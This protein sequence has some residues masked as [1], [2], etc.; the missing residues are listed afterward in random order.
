MTTMVFSRQS[1]LPAEV[2][3]FV[4]RREELSRLRAALGTHRLVTLVGPGGVGKTRLA[5]RAARDLAD[6]TPD[7]PWLVELAD[8]RDPDLIADSVLAALGLRDKVQGT[9]EERLAAHLSQRETLLIL[10]NCEHLRDAAAALTA[11][12]LRSCPSLRI[13]TTTRHVLSVV[14]E[15]VIA[16]SPLPVPDGS[17]TGEALMRYDAVR[18]FVERA[19]A[20]HSAFRVTEDNAG[21]ITELVR[22][23]DGMPLAI[24]L[25]SVRVR[26]LTPQQILERLDDR[27][28]LLSRGDR[29]ASDRQQTLRG[30]IDWSYDLLSEPERRIWARASVFAGGFDLKALEE[31]CGEGFFSAELLLVVED[32]VSKSILE[33]EEAGDR[34]RFRMLQ[35]I[36]EY[37]AERLTESE[38]RTTYTVRHRSYY[39]AMVARARREL[40]GDRQVDWYRR[41]V[42]D[43]DNLRAA[44]ESYAE[45]RDQAEAGM[46]MVGDLLHHW[47]MAGRFSEGRHWVDRLLP[48]VPEGALERAMGLV[49]SG[50]LVVLQGDKDTG[51]RFLREA[52]KIAAEHDSATWEANALHGIATAEVFWGDSARAVELLTLALGRHRWGDDPLGT[53]LAL[54]QLATAH[55]NLGNRDEALGHADECIRLSAVSYDRWCAALAEWT[56][57]HVQ[58]R[59]GET[60]QAVLHA[61]R[62]LE[63]KKPFGDRLGMAMS[64]EVIAWGRAASGQYAEAGYL[65]GAVLSA[66]RSIGADL[67]Q[68]LQDEHAATVATCREALGEEAFQ[69]ALDAG[70]S[71]SFGRSVAM[72][73]GETAAPAPTPTTVTL[74]KRE[75]QIADLIA[76][77]LTNRE[78]ADRLFISQRTAEGHVDR[79]MKKLGVSTRAQIAAWVAAHRRAV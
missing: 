21:S 35:S 14:G 22:R 3:S 13:L 54:V 30:L 5:V 40:Y 61:R 68:H 10:D 49:V 56:K 75:G 58:W 64:M 38:E 33:R 16:V 32:L 72:A 41:L 28:G 44:L 26:A 53:P 73:L 42:A 31:V 67:F 12:L 77:G 6:T 47:V 36:Q 46:R 9:A 52:R 2:S 45:E 71:A 8:L 79:A 23:L 57:A 34:L 62:T 70:A 63:L 17:V 4:G 20:S 24:E 78:I 66:L 65:L 51:Q 50:R 48:G 43:H 69:Q 11:D 27:F 76:E 1:N 15:H 39:T 18:L 59:Y 29:S 55:A 60:E 37:G 7:G 74:T 19:G 25:A